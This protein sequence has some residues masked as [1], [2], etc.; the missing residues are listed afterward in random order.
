MEK[1]VSGNNSL[2][3]HSAPGSCEA[4][5][6]AKLFIPISILMKLLSAD[7]YTV[8][9]KLNFLYNAELPW[10][11][12]LSCFNL[13]KTAKDGVVCALGQIVLC[14]TYQQHP[15]GSRKVD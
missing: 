10:S 3:L 11:Q 15:L 4:E 8:G 7:I 1:F 6:P 5:L 9:E 13:N 14:C 12:F 2:R